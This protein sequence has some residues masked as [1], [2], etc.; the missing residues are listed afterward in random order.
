M[1]SP[2]WLTP[3]GQ[4]RDPTSFIPF[5]SGKRSCFGKTF[6]EIAPRVVCSMILD[7]F[8]LS[9][10]DPKFT[11]FVPCYIVSVAMPPNVHFVLKHR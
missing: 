3:N 1:D 2:Y 5:L 4:K 11:E 6:A 8:E 9:L 10:A 7:K